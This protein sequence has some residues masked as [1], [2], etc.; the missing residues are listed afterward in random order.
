MDTPAILLALPPRWRYDVAPAM[1]KEFFNAHFYPHEFTR[2]AWFTNSLNYYLSC[3]FFNAF[4]LPQR[5]AGTR[6]TL[7]YI[8]EITARR[9]LDSDLPGG[10]AAP[11]G[12]DGAFPPRRR[13][14]RRPAR[15]SGRPGAARGRRQGARTRRWKWP[16]RGPVRVS[17]G[18]PCDSEGD[19]YDALTKQVEDAVRELEIRH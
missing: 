2:K 3:L 6:Q 13:H 8:G 1:A 7:R 19:D 11:D 15:R 14:D 9:L 5:E 18:A 16:K 17:F 4:P 12:G 10:Q